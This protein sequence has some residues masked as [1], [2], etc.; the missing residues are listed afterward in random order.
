MRW[1]PENLKITIAGVMVI[2]QKMRRQA[3]LDWNTVENALQ[4]A[5]QLQGD[6][7]DIKQHSSVRLPEGS[8][9]SGPVGEVGVQPGYCNNFIHPVRLHTPTVDHP[10]ARDT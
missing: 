7:Q 2:L 5:P 9:W 6:D 8:D 1:L 10:Y 3:T 4:T